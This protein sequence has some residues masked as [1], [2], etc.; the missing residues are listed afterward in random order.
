MKYNKSS[1]TFNLQF[2][3]LYNLIPTTIRPTNLAAL[4]HYYEL[5]PPPYRWRLEGNN[6]QK[7]ELALSTCL[8]FE[9]KNRRTGYSFG[10]YDSHKELSSLIPVIKSLQDR[11]FLLESQSLN[12]ATIISREPFLLGPIY[13][14]FTTCGQECGCEEDHDY[15][16]MLNDQSTSHTLFKPHKETQPPDHLSSQASYSHVYDENFGYANEEINSNYVKPIYDTFVFDNDANEWTN[17]VDQYD[18]ND[19]CDESASEDIFEFNQYLDLYK[20][21]ANPLFQSK[22]DKELGTIKHVPPRRNFILMIITIVGAFQCF[23]IHVMNLLYIMTTLF[24][25]ETSL[26][27]ILI[28]LINL[29]IIPRSY[30]P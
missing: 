8:D 10:I 7:I 12:H 1:L 19:A 26:K 25:I 21:L 17:D 27:M 5:L 14:E 23:L 28:C 16:M 9:E 29:W 4:L 30:K 13:D 11:K 2:I 20:I 15:I 6:V 22:E 18:F 24:L 3:K